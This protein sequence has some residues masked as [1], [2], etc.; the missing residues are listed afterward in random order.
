MNKIINSIGDDFPKEQAR[1]REILGVYKEI[2]PPGQFGAMMIEQV[3]ARADK[4][5]LSGDVVEIVKSY[6]E[7]IEIKE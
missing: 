7:L 3:L 6:K 4:A 5:A 2:G 1:A